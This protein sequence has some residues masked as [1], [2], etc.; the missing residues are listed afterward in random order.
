M[1]YSASRGP[2][3]YITN[4]ERLGL[5]FCFV[6]C[7]DLL[8]RIAK[9][10]PKYVLKQMLLYF[11]SNFGAKIQLIINKVKEIKNF[12]SPYRRRILNQELEE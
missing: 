5:F 3:A 2:N 11:A 1:A 4:T 10:L 8:K 6:N 7:P 9:T 12:L